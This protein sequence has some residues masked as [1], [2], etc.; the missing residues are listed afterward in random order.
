MRTAR[1]RRSLGV[2]APL[3]SPRLTLALLPLLAIAVVAVSAD[4]GPP[5]AVLAAPLG[6]LAANLAA[7]IATR[8]AFRT[9]PALLAFHAALLAVLALAA[10]GRLTYLKGTLE[11]SEGE[12]FAGVL[13][14][15]ESGPLHVPGLASAAFSNLGFTVDY[16][17]GLKRGRT[18]NRVAF[19]DPDGRGGERVIG[20][21]APLKLLG[22]RIYTTSNKGFAPE[23]VWRPHGADAQRG[24]L[25]LPSFPA[26]LEHQQVEWS[27]PGSALVVQARL[28]LEERVVDLEA[29][30]RL[31]APE[32]HV[33]VIESGGETARL[34]P[35]DSHRLAGGTLHYERLR[36]WMGYAVSHDWTLPW[37][38]AASV[39]AAAALAW[40]YAGRFRAR[41]WHGAREPA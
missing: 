36:L 33:L 14:S 4:A 40:H 24:T 10:A 3:G 7:A 38:L 35:G 5:S 16:E 19:R 41:P 37:M 22:Y 34:R 9:Q 17:P 15:Q 26:A 28:E 39:V 13:H 2:L 12:E 30:W 32:R 23:L 1:T 11:L 25:H 21:H 6:A 29:P 27:P 20:D 18:L 31:R 8:A